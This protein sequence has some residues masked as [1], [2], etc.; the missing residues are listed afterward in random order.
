[1]SEKDPCLE[2]FKAMADKGVNFE[3]LLVEALRR[4]STP[5]KRL[6]ISLV[7]PWVWTLKP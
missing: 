2:H 7:K 5:A 6:L 4:Q 1:M 3:R